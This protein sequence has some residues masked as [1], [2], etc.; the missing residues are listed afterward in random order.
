MRRLLKLTEESSSS[1]KVD[2]EVFVIAIE[3]INVADIAIT[4][5]TPLAPRADL[6][7]EGLS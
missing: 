6:L 3:P 5:A 1:S 4:L 2:D 7:K